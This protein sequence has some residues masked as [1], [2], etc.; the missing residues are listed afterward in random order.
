MARS[1]LARPGSAS[2]CVDRPGWRV[3][4][5]F[6]RAASTYSLLVVF[7]WGCDAPWRWWPRILDLLVEDSAPDEN[8]ASTLSLPAVA[9]ST[10]VVV[11]LG[12]IVV[13]PLALPTQQR[14][15]SE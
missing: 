3:L 2:G 8:H 5:E 11:L 10:D 9:A 4:A 15:I 13:E 6:L 14:E 12:G 1:G 7:A